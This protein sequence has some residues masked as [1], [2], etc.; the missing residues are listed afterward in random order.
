MAA[1]RKRAQRSSAAIDAL[2]VKMLRGDPRRQESDATR[3]WVMR[4]LLKGV[5]KAEVLALAEMADEQYERALVKVGR[6]YRERCQAYKA[7]PRVVRPLAVPVRPARPA[8]WP[9]W[10]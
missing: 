3:E 10:R 4:S 5:R 2:R 1:A 7:L 9:F 8:W 6:W